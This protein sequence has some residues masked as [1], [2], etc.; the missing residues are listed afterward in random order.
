MSHS[1]TLNTYIAIQMAV[2]KTHFRRRK[3]FVSMWMPTTAW[4][5]RISISGFEFSVWFHS[6]SDCHPDRAEIEIA[7]FSPK[8]VSF[9]DKRH[10]PISS[11]ENTTTNTII[12]YAKSFSNNNQIRSDG[13]GWVNLVTRIGKCHCVCTC[14]RKKTD[15][16]TNAQSDF[17]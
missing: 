3:I 2:T 13:L 12:V 6:A 1:G 4:L 14:R 11:V 7:F 16:N 5:P 8:S 15:T 9:V 10:F 17:R